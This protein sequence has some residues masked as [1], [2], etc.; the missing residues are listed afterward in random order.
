MTGHRLITTGFPFAKGHF[1]CS[2]RSSQFHKTQ[3]MFPLMESSYNL[4]GIL[5]HNPENLIGEI[6]KNL[7]RIFY[8]SRGIALAAIKGCEPLGGIW[9]TCASTP[10]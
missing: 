1:S 4:L 5:T 7:S 6:L 10:G 8:S 3:G 9:A 2:V